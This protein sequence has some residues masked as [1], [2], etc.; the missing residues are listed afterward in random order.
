MSQLRLPSLTGLFLTSSHLPTEAAVS[1]TLA[2]VNMTSAGHVNCAFKLIS[3]SQRR[4]KAE[5]KESW[6]AHAFVTEATTS[7]FLPPSARL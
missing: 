5:I 7:I 3:I 6:M 1:R 2:V 4:G